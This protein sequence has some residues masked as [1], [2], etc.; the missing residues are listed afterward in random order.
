MLQCNKCGADLTNGQ[1]KEG[2]SKPKVMP[3]GSTKPGG[4]PYKMVK[5]ACGGCAFVPY[6]AS[7]SRP[8]YNPPV[9]QGVQPSDKFAQLELR[10]VSIDKKLDEMKTLITKA[11]KA[12]VA[13]EINGSVDGLVS[14]PAD[15]TWEE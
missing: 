5:C 11:A 7:Q 6:G 3:D 9:P 4:K 14:D 2:I 1:V 12:A 15:L 13:A 10:L 8:A